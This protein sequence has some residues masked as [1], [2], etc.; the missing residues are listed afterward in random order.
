MYLYIYIY[1]TIQHTYTNPLDPTQFHM[2]GST[3]TWGP[4]GTKLECVYFFSYVESSWRSRASTHLVLPQGDSR[5][6]PHQSTSRCGRLHSLLPLNLSHILLIAVDKGE[7]RYEEDLVHAQGVPRTVL[8][9]VSC[10]RTGTWP[11]NRC[12]VAA[13]SILLTR[14]HLYSH[15]S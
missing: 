4:R 1:M 5:S 10:Y 9:K 3:P 7:A 14:S 11:L 13:E 15:I 6:P 2:M 12:E 8:E